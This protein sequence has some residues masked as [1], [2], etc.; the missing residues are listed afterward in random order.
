MFGGCTID[1]FYAWQFRRCCRVVV[2]RILDRPTGRLQERAADRITSAGL[3]LGG[4]RGPRSAT[5]L[6]AI[7]GIGRC[8]CRRSA[9]PHVPKR[10]TG[11]GRIQAPSADS[12][13]G[14]A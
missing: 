6:R 11:T 4:A 13:Y 12:R 10:H 3:A 7:A 8:D 14:Q 5:G 1:R 2:L 9:P